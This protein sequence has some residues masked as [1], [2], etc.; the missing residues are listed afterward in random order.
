M[1]ILREVD[2]AEYE[3]IA[4]DICA[5]FTQADTVPYMQHT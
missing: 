1:G 2:A 4:A 3:Q 5:G